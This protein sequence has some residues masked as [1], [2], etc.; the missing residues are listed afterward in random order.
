LSGIAGFFEVDNLAG[1]A[2]RDLL[3][4][5]GRFQAHRGPDAEGYFQEGSTGLGHRRLVLQDEVGGDQPMYSADGRYVLVMNG[6]VY[7]HLDLR[8]ELEEL[9]HSFTSASDAE[10]V[11]ESRVTSRRARRGSGIVGWC[12]RTRSVG[13]SR[14]IRRM[15]VMCWS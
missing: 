4:R 3:Q 8:S 9:G 2:G 15:A 11:L 13:T 7:N 1:Q 6:T 10:V 14:C 5:M 12:C